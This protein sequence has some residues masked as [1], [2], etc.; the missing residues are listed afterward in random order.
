MFRAMFSRSFKMRIT[1]HHTSPQS[2]AFIIASLTGHRH[3]E[4]IHSYTTRQ[5]EHRCSGHPTYSS[6]EHGTS[7]YQ[8]SSQR[9]GHSPRTSE[10]KNP[11]RQSWWSSDH[12]QQ[13]SGILSYRRTKIRCPWSFWNHR[14]LCSVI[15][16]IQVLHERFYSIM[17]GT[18]HS[19][20]VHNQFCWFVRAPPPS[21]NYVSNS[22]LDIPTPQGSI[23]AYR[24]NC[25]IFEHSP[26]A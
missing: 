20:N 13:E 22:L 6:V 7:S 21:S 14:H 11:S 19:D 16:T 15:C 9:G 10:E 1:F 5:E 18:I 12:K 8:R 17:A 3:G 4:G 24:C 2:V 26:C 25:R 23:Q